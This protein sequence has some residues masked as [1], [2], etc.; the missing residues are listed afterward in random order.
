LLAHSTDMSLELS[1]I[2]QIVFLLVATVVVGIDH[3]TQHEQEQQQQQQQNRGRLTYAVLLTAHH[4]HFHEPR[5]G[6]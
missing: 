6:A 2:A 5:R 1:R 3:P 4:C